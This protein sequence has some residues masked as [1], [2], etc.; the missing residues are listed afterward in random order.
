MADETTSDLEK[1]RAFRPALS[2]LV[3]LLTELNSRPLS[4]VGIPDASVQKLEDCAE[5]VR[6]C[7]AEAAKCQAAVSA[8]QSELDKLAD[9]GASDKD[10]K[11]SAKAIHEAEQSVLIAQSRL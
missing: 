1:L 6:A 4:Y 5:A 9:K 2:E 10:L 7:K 8:A 3:A 11:T